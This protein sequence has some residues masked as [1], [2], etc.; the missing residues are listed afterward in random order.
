MTKEEQV[1]KWLNEHA[2][3]IVGVVGGLPC[4]IW[5]SLDGTSIE[6]MVLGRIAREEE[7][8]TNANAG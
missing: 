6:D 8:E 1:L 5:S 7:E 3:A 4:L 2:T